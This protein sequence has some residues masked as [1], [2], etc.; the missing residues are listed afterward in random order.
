MLQF[1]LTDNYET[2]KIK[3]ITHEERVISR[4]HDIMFVETSHLNKSTFT[5]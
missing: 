5:R 2:K 3:K 1:S 4:F